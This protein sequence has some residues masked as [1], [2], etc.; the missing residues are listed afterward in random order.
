MTRKISERDKFQ[1]KGQSE[2]RVILQAYRKVT[3]AVQR[4]CAIVQM[5]LLVTRC[6]IPNSVSSVELSQVKVVKNGVGRGNGGTAMLRHR[7]SYHIIIR[8]V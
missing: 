8:R 6:T 5:N 4:Y 2:L 3:Q 1:S 7:C